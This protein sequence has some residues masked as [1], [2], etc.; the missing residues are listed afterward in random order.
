M[1]DHLPTASHYR[2]AIAM[3]E[4]LAELAADMDIDASEAPALRVSEFT[5]EVQLLMKQV[6]LLQSLLQ[7][8]SRKRINFPPLPKVR[9]AM[10]AVRE[11]RRRDRRARTESLVA[12]AQRRWIEEHPDET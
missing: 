3:D 12:A 9:T 5:P 8:R 10:Q 2:E 7:Q 11:R 1:I 4:E 6:Q